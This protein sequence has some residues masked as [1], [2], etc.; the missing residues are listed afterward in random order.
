[1]N[2]WFL[3]SCATTTITWHSA[4]RT[5]RGGKRNLHRHSRV[6]R[7]FSLDEF[8]QQRERF[9]PAEIASFRRNDARNTLLHD[10]QLRAARYL[11]QGD[12]HVD[13]AGQVRIV[14]LVRIAD[15]L[16]WYQLKI[17]AAERVTLARGEVGERHL[18]SPA[19][20]RIQVVNLCGEAVRR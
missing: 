3:C 14:K 8:R 11:L 12:G 6:I 16:V 17:F 5:R 18:V 10:V 19:D 4:C 1:M 7:N 13:H 9:L 2:A 15:A 20:L